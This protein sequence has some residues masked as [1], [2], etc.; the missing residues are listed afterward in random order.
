MSQYVVSVEFLALIT[1]ALE[2]LEYRGGGGGGQ[3]LDC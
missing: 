3:G 2:G 1:L